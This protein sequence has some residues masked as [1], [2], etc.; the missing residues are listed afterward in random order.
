M[1]AY[2]CDIGM[3]FGRCECECGGSIRRNVKSGG[4][5]FPL[6]MHMDALEMH[7]KRNIQQKIN[8]EVIYLFSW[9]D[10]QINKSFI[11]FLLL[12]DSVNKD[13]DIKK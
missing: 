6:D 8:Y 11:I 12:F 13:I 3:V 9:N 5:N 7:E 4:H 2:R 1:N 10:K